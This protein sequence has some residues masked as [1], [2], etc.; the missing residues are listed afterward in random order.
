MGM[1]S[2]SHPDILTFIHAKNDPA[3]FTNFN[4]SVKFPDVF[5]N[6]FKDNPQTLHVVINPRT[7]KRYAM[8]HFLRVVYYTIEDLLPEGRASDD[9]Y[10]LKEIWEMIIKGASATGEHSI[11]FID[12]VNEANPTP[13]SGKIEATNPC[14]ETALTV[15]RVAQ[16][17][18]N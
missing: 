7:K 17:G 2:I 1:V 11:F 3:A 12:R 5:M 9:C 18:F 10:T 13:H 6:Q 14:G 16:C 15:F 8:P 4:L